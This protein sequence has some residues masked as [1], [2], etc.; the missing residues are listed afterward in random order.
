[1]RLRIYREHMAAWLEVE[2]ESAGCFLRGWAEKEAIMARWPRQKGGDGSPESRCTC[3]TRKGRI[4]GPMMF[5]ASE[6]LL[7]F[8]LLVRKRQAAI[9][10]LSRHIAKL[11]ATGR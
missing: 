7:L 6:K 10:C 5:Q 3:C 4:D 11:R 2:H 1:M 8:S 9:V